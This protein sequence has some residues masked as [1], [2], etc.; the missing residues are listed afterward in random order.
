MI[1]FLLLPLFIAT[2]AHAADRPNAILFIADDVS[3]NDL[4]CYGNA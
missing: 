3:W 1:R 4:G 2:A